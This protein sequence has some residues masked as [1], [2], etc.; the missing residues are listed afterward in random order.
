MTQ[1]KRQTTSMPLFEEELTVEKRAVE[2]G[3]V[4]ITTKI[5]ERHEW[6]EQALRREEVSVERVP[7]GRVVTET[8]QVREEGDV[9]IVPILEEELVI[10]KRLVL[11]EELHVRK[12]MRVEEVREPVTLREEHATVTREDLNETD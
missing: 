5:E 3:R 11:K 6:V 8:P 4:R 12:N 2:T 9:L 10:E 1:E 7:V